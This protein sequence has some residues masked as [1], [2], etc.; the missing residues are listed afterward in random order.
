M[1]ERNRFK[2]ARSFRL[3][4]VSTAACAS[5]N[6]HPCSKVMSCHVAKDFAT[7]QIRRKCKNKRQSSQSF[8]QCRRE[9]FRKRSSRNNGDR[10][11][12]HECFSRCYNNLLGSAQGPFSL[13]PRSSVT[14]GLHRP[15][16]LT[17]V[18]WGI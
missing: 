4:Y 13:P 18:S 17:T 10:L 15:A 2:E 11:Q 14:K 1:N 6:R 9:Y 7:F 8:K 5:R 12:N 3:K 16:S